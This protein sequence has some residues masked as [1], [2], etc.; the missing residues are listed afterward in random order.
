[1]DNLPKEILIGKPT[2][3]TYL[4]GERVLREWNI[5]I[6][7]LRAPN[8]DTVYMIGD[9]SASDIQG[10]NSFQS[11][12]GLEWKSILVETGVYKAGDEPPVKP[13]HIVAN[14]LEAVNLVVQEKEVSEDEIPATVPSNSLSWSSAI[15]SLQAPAPCK[16]RSFKGDGRREYGG[17]RK[18]S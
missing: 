6:N 2:E 16:L 17:E 5:E 14:V 11:P 13:D 18:P 9:N 10:A 4:Y 8:I 12:N 15:P 3:A 1:M 7:G